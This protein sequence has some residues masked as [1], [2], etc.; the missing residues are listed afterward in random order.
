MVPLRNPVVAFWREA[1]VLEILVRFYRGNGMDIW[2]QKLVMSLYSVVD[3]DECDV[4]SG[5][6]CRLI[7]KM[8]EEEAQAC[9]GEDVV[10]F[11]LLTQ[12]C[13]K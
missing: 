12:N 8:S 2:V 6:N 4:S 13:Q 9:G 11:N 7:E 5:C 10:S 1:Q 3:V